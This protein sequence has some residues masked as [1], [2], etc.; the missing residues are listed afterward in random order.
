[1][2][3]IIR[4]AS[5]QLRTTCPAAATGSSAARPGRWLGC[6]GRSWATCPP[7]HLPPL[8]GAAPEAAEWNALGPSARPCRTV[9]REPREAPARVERVCG[10][11]GVR[12]ECGCRAGCDC[13]PTRLAA[14]G[15]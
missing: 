5:H 1:M 2:I 9:Y 6:C 10:G 15:D 11:D 3:S 12:E 7:P 14:D 8:R 4:V 13:E